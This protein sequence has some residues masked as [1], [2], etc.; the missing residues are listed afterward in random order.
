MKWIFKFQFFAALI[1]NPKPPWSSP[2]FIRGSSV[3]CWCSCFEQYSLGL[4]QVVVLLLLGRST[5][6][7]CLV[8]MYS[9]CKSDRHCPPLLI[10]NNCPTSS[11]PHGIDYPG[12][13]L[14][15]FQVSSGSLM[16]PRS[17]SPGID[18]QRFKWILYKRAL[19]DWRIATLTSHHHHHPPPGTRRAMPFPGFWFGATL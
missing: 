2:P 8:A 11:T 14:A 12:I 5:N 7:I 15:P 1:G 4:R 17:R 19:V 9:N 10:S 18:R 16:E 13:V 3:F 6:G